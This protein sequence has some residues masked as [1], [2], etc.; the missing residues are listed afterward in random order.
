MHSHQKGTDAFKKSVY[1]SEKEIIYAMKPIEL[2]TEIQLFLDYNE[3]LVLQVHAIID[4]QAELIPLFLT[5]DEATHLSVIYSKQLSKLLKKN[6]HHLEASIGTISDLF[7]GGQDFTQL[8]QPL[9]NTKLPTVKYLLIELRK[10]DK[11][12]QL[13]KKVTQKQLIAGRQQQLISTSPPIKQRN[14]FDLTPKVK[15]VSIGNHTFIA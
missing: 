10:E 13:L 8:D 4:Q 7:F 6:E 12:V 9:S 11:K 14:V 1:L 3:P 15:A 5:R 2:T